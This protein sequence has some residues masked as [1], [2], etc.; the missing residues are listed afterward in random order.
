MANRSTLRPWLGR[1]LAAVCTL[2]LLLSAVASHEPDVGG[3]TDE[4]GSSATPDVGNIPDEPFPALQRARQLARLGVDRW[5][6]QGQRGQGIKAAILDSGFRGYRAHLGKAL[7]VQVTVR[8]FRRDGNLEAKDSQHGILCGEVLHALVPDAEL[9]LA[10]WEPE[11]ADQF[12]AAA[13]WARE[14]G[15][16]IISCSVIIPTWSDG[17]GHGR[18]HEELSSILGNGSAAGDL[19]LFASAGNIAQRHWAGPFHPGSDGCHEWQPGQAD[20][21]LTPWSTDPVSVEMCW[22]GDAD[23]DVSVVDATSGTE[24]G[25][26]HDPSAARCRCA[27]VRFTPETRHAYVV[28]LRLS[29]G[30]PGTFHLATLGSGLAC[31]TAR[32]SICFPGDGPEVVAV[33]AV[34]REG[35]RV[36][37]SSCGPNSSQPKPDLVAMVPFASLWRPRPFAGTSAAAPQAAGVAALLWGRHPQWTAQ[38]VRQA[39]TAS[40]QD[41]GPIGHDYETG[42]G[43]IQLSEDPMK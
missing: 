13:L 28:R 22:Q 16:R 5:H 12:L 21:L 15:A 6:K 40:A 35:R 33:G 43:L 9:L 17:E 39:L 29:Q 27:V 26:G 10:N 11:R 3:A 42:Y 14:Q 41:L 34:D 37:Y 20:N 38:Q 8:S 18:I 23:Y 32:G 19:L 4:L 2:V 7:P 31:S 25:R 30:Q 24:I 36:G 1:L